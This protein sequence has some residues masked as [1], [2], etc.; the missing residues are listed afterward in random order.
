M[1]NVFNILHEILNKDKLS[2]LFQFQGIVFYLIGSRIQHNSHWNV[3]LSK[4][5]SFVG[6]SYF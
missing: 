2:H 5:F 1:L 3:Q 6:R 4:F